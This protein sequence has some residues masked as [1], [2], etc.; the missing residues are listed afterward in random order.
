MDGINVNCMPRYNV[1]CFGLQNRHFRN[2]CVS[3]SSTTDSPPTERVPDEV[4]FVVLGLFM[5]LTRRGSEKHQLQIISKLHRSISKRPCTQSQQIHER[6]CPPESN[7]HCVRFVSLP[8]FSSSHLLL[9]LAHSLSRPASG[10]TAHPSRISNHVDTGLLNNQIF[11]RPRYEDGQ[12]RGTSSDTTYSATP[13]KE[14]I[15]SP[16]IIWRAL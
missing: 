5:L 16:H 1:N 6:R 13:R 3:N 10:H 7:N 2:Q 8:L 12:H 9:R 4:G 14:P 15:L 11:V